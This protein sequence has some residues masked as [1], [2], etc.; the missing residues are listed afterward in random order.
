MGY[1]RLLFLFFSFWGKKL[2]SRNV[3][4]WQLFE[5]KQTLKFFFTCGEQDKKQIPEMCTTGAYLK[6]LKH[7]PMKAN[8]QFQD[9]CFF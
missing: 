9:L 7:A 6:V 5:T 3:Y 4:N 2:N 1:L 8:L